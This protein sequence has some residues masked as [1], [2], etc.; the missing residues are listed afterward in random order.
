MS[1]ELDDS[2]AFMANLDRRF[3]EASGLSD[4]SDYSIFYSRL[5]PA[6]L[7]V[8][9]IKPGGARDGT[10]QLASQSFYEDWSHEYVDMDY[11]IAAVMR[12]ALMRALGA[13]DAEELRGVPKINSFFQ[14][15]R[16]VDDFTPK[17]MREN[18]TMCAP[19]VEE[20]IRY[21]SP[22]VLIFEGLAARDNVVRHLCRQVVEDA[23]HRIE[24]MRRGAMSTFFKQE[25]A[26]IPA[27]SRRVQLLTLGHPSHFGYLPDW[28]TAIDAMAAHLGRSFLPG[29]GS[30]SRQERKVP[31]PMPAIQ[32]AS[33]RPSASVVAHRSKYD[34]RRFS[35]AKKPPESFRYSPIHDF[36]Q[37]LVKTGPMTVDE[38]FNHLQTVGWQRPSGKPLTASIVRTDLVSMVKHGFA[39]ASAG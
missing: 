37:E 14:R 33:Q 36:W 23:T 10:H 3:R 30:K 24:G 2:S 9:G 6:R 7:I 21:V 25:S 31:S 11:R 27:L 38:F 32:A 26:L 39:L 16:G 35:A 17:E 4:R 13:H 20:I 1:A 19:F 29:W 5:Q 8:I 28:P 22:E 12:P 34:P 18:V 15:A